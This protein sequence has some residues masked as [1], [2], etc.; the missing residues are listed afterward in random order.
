MMNIVRMQFG[1]HVYG[2]NLPTSD[3]DFKGV[4]LPGGY[5]LIMQNAAKHIQKNTK[6]DPNAKNNPDDVDEELFSVSTYL[7]LLAEGQTVA[8]DML[9]T[10]AGFYT[11][12][13]H[14]IWIVI[15]NHK[16][17]LI[18]SD[19]SSFVGYCKTQAAKY[20]LKGGRVE[21]LRRALEFLK[22]HPD[23][24]KLKDIEQE[25]A[26]FVYPGDLYEG[27]GSDLLIK[28]TWC[29]SPRN[30]LEKHLEVCNRK[31]PLHCTVKY[32]REIF[33]RIF[34]QY[35]Q[36]AL[37]AEK[38]EGIDWKALMHAVRVADEAHELLTT[39]N[40]TFPRPNAKI[41]KKIRTGQLAYKKV[42][43]LIEGGLAQIEADKKTSKLRKKPDQ[44]TIDEI[45]YLAHVMQIER[46]LRSREGV[47]S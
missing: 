17:K 35:G 36:R 19:I 15:Q 44:S 30:E 43:I 2:T 3:Q 20:G 16:D 10:P 28:F 32:A 34:D 14:P 22:Q 1:S 40:I 11:V 46:H 21:A 38:N 9:F 47:L 8:L 23:H 31:V 42:E 6:K 26:N 29:K 41:L 12:E 39:G 24:V 33:Q 13:P 4:F 7:R 37:M 18:H 5:E 27:D 45:V 25:V